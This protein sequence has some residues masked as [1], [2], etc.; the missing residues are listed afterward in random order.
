MPN[1]PLRQIS[2]EEMKEYI[3]S[4]NSEPMTPERYVS[5]TEN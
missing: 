5:V 3:E 1:W 2:H 4:G